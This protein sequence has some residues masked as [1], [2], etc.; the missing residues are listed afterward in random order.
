MADITVKVTP[1]G[2]RTDALTCTACGVLDLMEHEDVNEFVYDHLFNY[3][4]CDPNSTRI[5]EV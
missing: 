4:E 2:Q 5:E 3:H 1:L